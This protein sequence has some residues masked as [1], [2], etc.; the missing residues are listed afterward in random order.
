LWCD[1][2]EDDYAASFPKTEKQFKPGSEKGRGEE[3]AGEPM[4]KPWNGPID[5]LESGL[6]LV[7]YLGIGGMGRRGFGRMKQVGK[8]QIEG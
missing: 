8:W 2:I 1:V 6:K 4:A 7:E 3:N 5:V